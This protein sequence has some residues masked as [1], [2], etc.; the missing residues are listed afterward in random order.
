MKRTVL[1]FAVFTFIFTSCV[2][3]SSEYK[4]LQAKND[5]LALAAAKVNVELDQIMTLLNEVEDNF[6]SIKSAENYL[7]VQ[8]GGSGELSPSVRDR[9][10]GDMQFITETLDKNRQ[11][12]S[13]LEAKLKKSNLNS[14]QLT[15]TLANLRQELEDK[16]SSLV[17]LREEL[18][19]RDRQIADLTENVTLLSD[20]VK[21]LAA[22]SS[23]RQDVIDRQQTELNTV[24]YCFGTAKEL[25]DQKILVNGQLGVNFNHDYFIRID[26]LNGLKVVPLYA[27]QGKLISKHPSG[28]YAF[29]QD[30]SGQAELRI[31][32]PKHFWSLTKYLVIEVR[33]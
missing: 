23:A 19:K 8:S 28:S 27:K 29:A 32:D 11:Q 22:E 1:F 31:L 26:N 12:I 13:N 4:A 2:K 16:T 7:S 18:T 20:N 14:S 6:Q 15:K 25:K 33:V 30:A 24:Y 3:N 10:Q 17:S 5:S 21:S 9:I